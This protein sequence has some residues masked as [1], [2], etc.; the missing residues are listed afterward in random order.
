LPGHIVLSAQGGLVRHL[1]MPP[2]QLFDWFVHAAPQKPQLLMSLLV[3]TQPVEQQLCPVGHGAPPAFVEQLHMPPGPPP[4]HTSAWFVLG[5]AMQ[6]VQHIGDS[7][8]V[9]SQ[10]L[11]LPSQSS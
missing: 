9:P 10:S 2:V 11:S 4:T 8:I 3:S 1:H 6:P 7:S 5:S